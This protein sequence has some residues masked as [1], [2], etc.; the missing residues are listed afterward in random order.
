MTV[1]ELIAKLQTL[2]P[3]LPVVTWAGYD[4]WWKEV[5]AVTADDVD[6]ESDRYTTKTVTIN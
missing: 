4:G 2:D 3:E 5:Q 1:A 6:I